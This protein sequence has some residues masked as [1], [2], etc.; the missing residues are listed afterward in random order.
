M[1]REKILEK[2]KNKIDL[3]VDEELFYLTEIAG[4]SREEAETMITV[5]ENKDSNLLID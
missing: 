2:V 4:Y 3:T 1:D 5:A